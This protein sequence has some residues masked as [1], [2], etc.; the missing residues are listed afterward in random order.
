MLLVSSEKPLPVPTSKRLSRLFWWVR[1]QEK[2]SYVWSFRPNHRQLQG[3]VWL[4][5]NI[6]RKLVSPQQLAHSQCTLVFL[7]ELLSRPPLVSH[8]HMHFCIPSPGISSQDLFNGQLGWDPCQAPLLRPLNWALWLNHISLLC[9]STFP[10]LA[11]LFSL[12]PNESVKRQ[13]PVVVQGS[14][15]VTWFSQAEQDSPDPH[16]G[17]FH[18]WKYGTREPAP[19]DYVVTLSKLKFD[20]YFWF[21]SLFWV[22]QSLISWH[23][24]LKIAWLVFIFNCV[25]L[26]SCIV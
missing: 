3:C 6:G 9:L 22:P 25:I 21:G 17:P 19:F 12:Q 14:W 10:L 7:R 4:A 18:G 16:L 24:F 13:E 2:R 5:A 20:F 26:L 1:L 8:A 11:F 23:F 15:A